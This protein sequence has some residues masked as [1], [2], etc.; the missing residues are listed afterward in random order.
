MVGLQ[1][2]ALFDQ[3]DEDS[4]GLVSARDLARG[5]LP[6]QGGGGGEGEPL[7]G[8]H[9]DLFCSLNR[10]PPTYLPLPSYSQHF[11]RRHPHP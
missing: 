11:H 5:S 9:Y 3:L 2:H 6:R 8:L 4:D 10:L 7:S 1:A